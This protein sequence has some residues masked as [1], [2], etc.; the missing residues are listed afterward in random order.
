MKAKCYTEEEKRLMIERVRHNETGIQNKEYKKYQ[1]IEAISD[2]FVWC[3]V[4]LITVGN[5]VIGGLGVFSNLIIREFGFTL[6]QTQL[7]N[8]A[9]GALTIIIMLSS[10]YVSQKSGQTCLTMILWT[11]PAVVGTIVILVVTPAPSNAGGMLIAFYCTQFFLAQGNM[12][13]SLITRN[14]AGQ[15]KKGIT[16]TAVFIGW[17]VGNLIAPQI[18]Q[19]KDAPRY[20]PGFVVH[21]GVYGAYLI[22]VVITRILLMSKNRKKDSIVSEITHDLAFQDLTDTENPNFRYVY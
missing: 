16:M 6:L 20:L 11:I 3:C 8:I 7:L 17:A 22:L 21:L 1:I 18:F 15:T 5:L 10:A 14:I 13:I 2:P 12:I 9:Q 19:E 4:L